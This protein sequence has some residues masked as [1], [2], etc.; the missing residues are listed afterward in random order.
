MSNLTGFDWAFIAANLV[1]AAG[2]GF[3]A[4]R[5]LPLFPIRLPSKVGAVAFFLLCASTHV[6]QLYHTLGDQTEQWGE[7][8]H[9]WHMQIIHV[10]QAVAVW[11]FAIGFFL[12]LRRLQA[13]RGTTDAADG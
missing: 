9:S 4:L 2:Y 8:V 11:V 10:P 13:E 1:I 3:I 5:V 12:D 6:D 7:I